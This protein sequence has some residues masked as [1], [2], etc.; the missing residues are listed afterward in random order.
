M[1]D[2]GSVAFSG[3]AAVLAAGIALLTLTRRPGGALNRSCAALFAVLAVSH[4]G[5][6]LGERAAG[7]AVWIAAEAWVPAL[8]RETGGCCGGWGRRG[9]PS[10][11]W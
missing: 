9:R 6:A 2:L 3:S 7:L 1:P 11:R 5:A 4:V 8:A 10:G